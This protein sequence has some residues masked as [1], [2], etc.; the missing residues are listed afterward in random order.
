MTDN[1]DSTRDTGARLRDAFDQLIDMDMLEREAWLAANVENP[2]QREILLRL[3]REDD[4]RGFLD[5]SI[6]A[7]ATRI[8]PGELKPDGLIGRQIGMFRIVRLLGQGGMASVFLGERTGRDFE[9]N[10]AVKILRRGLYSELEQRLFLRERQV[11]AGLTHPNVARM[12]DGGVTEAGIPYLVM[13][14]VDGVPITRFA[15][16]HA[17]TVRQRAELFLTVCRAVEAAHRNLIVHRDIKPSNILVTN[18]GVV[19]LLD[20]GIAKLI[21]EDNTDATGTVGVFTPNYAA[22]EQVSGGT[23]TTATDVYGLG[24]MLH[25]LLLGI[26]PEGMSTRRPSSRVTEALRTTQPDASAPMRSIQLRTALRG[27]LDNILL[28]ALAEEPELRYASAG[29]FADDIERYLKRRPVLA[30]PPSRWYRATKFVQRHRG[31]VALSI[32]FLLALLAAFGVT[33][34]QA[35]V[36][37]NEAGRA[38]ATRDFMVDLFQTASADLPRDERPTPQQLVEEAAKRARDDPDLVPEVRANL[39]FTLGKVTLANGDYKQAEVL[40]DDAIDRY[41]ALGESQSSAEWLGLLVAKGNLLNRT[42]RNSQADK[43]M[44]DVLPQLLAQESES[45]VSGLMLLGATRAYAGHADEAVTIAQQ[46]AR[47]A[48]QVFG[49][50][51]INAV[52]TLTYLGQLCAQVHRYRESV[53]LLEP[54]V[55]RWRKLQLPQDEEFARTLLHLASVK[56]HVGDSAS[57]E[58]LYREAI[59]L[60][61]RIFDKPHDRLA[62]ALGGYARF[63]TS[64]DRFDEAQSALEE[65][66]AIDRKVLG[67]QHVRTALLLDA[68]AM[69]DHARR[70][71]AAA[72][73]SADEAIRVLS[74]HAKEAGFEEEF[75]LARLHLADVLMSLNRFDA[76]SAQLDSIATDMPRLFGKVSAENADFI[77]A[78]GR[79]A[80]ARND[81]AASLALAQ[82]GTAIISQLDLPATETRIALLRVHAEASMALGNTVAALSDVAQALDAMRAANPEAH[83]QRTSLLAL[84]VRLESAAGDSAAATAAI[85]EARSLGVPAALLSQNDAAALKPNGN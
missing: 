12:I 23:I 34:W 35:N 11:L 9:Q 28:K 21:Q 47:K 57:V 7:H 78:N 25:E 19:K 5:T 44:A 81:A 2:E 55:A 20:F 60:M 45:A 53:A 46:A 17:L 36:A 58:A 65:A 85:A 63:L 4:G 40:L 62:T 24:V 15:A 31:G 16:A 54:A 29:A 70:D 32:V 84:N 27:D 76:A 49:A 83:V 30:H 18:D 59:A 82:R 22:P 77:R 48:E 8:D 50:D 64:Q 61:R 42:D 56:D 71:D 66:L 10:V 1:V 37:R 52:E 67:E 75:V 41:R 72:E 80:L 79:L 73:H 43:L 26:R 51:S 74:A 39:L 3:L 13:E 68:M 6:V 38:D 14:F 69:L 33:L